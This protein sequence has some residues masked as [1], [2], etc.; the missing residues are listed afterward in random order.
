MRPWTSWRARRD[1]FVLAGN[2]PEGVLRPPSR[3]RSTSL[4]TEVLHM[5]A[6]RLARCSHARLSA[7]RSRRTA[8]SRSRTRPPDG[9]LVERRAARCRGEAIDG[10]GS[11]RGLGGCLQGPSSRGVRRLPSGSGRARPDQLGMPSICF[12][13][14]IRAGS[15]GHRP[16]PSFSGQDFE[17]PPP[18]AP[19]F[20]PV[21]PTPLHGAA[22]DVPKLSG[23]TLEA[24][25]GEGKLRSEKCSL[26]SDTIIAPVQCQ[27]S[28]S[29]GP[30][31]YQRSA[32]AAQVQYDSDSTP[33]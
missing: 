19:D 23:R 30:V 25:G 31:E 24:G 28:A 22:G 27:C 11:A 14:E 15:T 5:L 4:D 20:E 6:S 18:P 32:S 2:A 1:E 12:C 3:I 16:R 29:V 17:R 8:L 33:E 9:V 21:L 10:A 13:G 7:A 26:G